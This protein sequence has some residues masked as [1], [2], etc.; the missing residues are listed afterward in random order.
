MSDLREQLRTSLGSQYT[1]ERELGG[2]GMSRVFVAT[3]TRFGR[4][5]VIK[6]LTR[7]SATDFSPARFE[8]EI[9]LAA[10]LQ[11]PH[12]VPVLNAGTAGEGIDAVPFYTMP[13]VEGESLRMRMRSYRVALSDA[14]MMLRDIATALAYA[15]DHGVVHRDIKPENILLSGRTAVVADFGIAKAISA[16]KTHSQSIDAAT[17]DGT[18]TQA[19]M[20]IGTPAYMSPEQAIGGV[21]DARTDI[22]AWGVIA[23]ELLTGAHPFIGKSSPQHLIAAHLTEQPRPIREV[24]ETIPPTL[25]SLVMRALEKDAA[26][27]PQLATELVRV[28]DDRSLLSGAQTV[29]AITAGAAPSRPAWRTRAA[30]VAAVVAVLIVGA[31]TAERGRIAAVLHA[32]ASKTADAD[33]AFAADSTSGAPHAIRLAV[34]PFDNLGDTADAYFADG[35]ADQVRGK[36]TEVSG[37][38]VIARTSSIAYRGTHESPQQIAH[39]LNV[40][41]LLTGTVR[42]AK[43]ANGASRVQVNPELV[44]VTDST[45][46]ASKWQQP[47]DAKLTDVFQVQTD[48]AT[49]VAS[50]LDIAL[51]ADV[52][53]QLAVRPTNSIAAYD[54]YLHGEN[55]ARGAAY[56][57]T[58][59]RAIAYYQQATNLDPNFTLAW[60][61]LSEAA[62]S[63]YYDGEPTAEMDA[64]ARDAADHAQSLAPNS[65]DTYR[66]LA[67]YAERVRDDYAKGLAYSE[68]G[69]R[70]SPSNATLISASAEAD[71]HLGHWTEALAQY[72]RSTSLDPRSVE[73]A[74]GL[75]RSSLYLRHYD[76][77]QVA[78]D[79][80]LALAPSDAIMLLRV[81]VDLA[82]GDSAAARAVI[83]RTLHQANPDA[84]IAT[85]AI[86]WD[87][88]W[89][90]PDVQQQRLEHLTPAAFGGDRGAWGLCL[91]ETYWLRGDTVH[92]RAYADSA[93]IAVEPQLRSMPNVPQHHEIL[94]LAL[95]YLGD[96]SAAIREG[97]RAVALVPIAKDAI[98]GPYYQHQLVR[99]YLIT[100]HPDKALDML[101][102]LLKVPYYLS[103]GWLRIDP[104]FAPL[105]GNPRFERLV[106]GN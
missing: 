48:I 96:D 2:G 49:K 78:L 80:G 65:P 46:P 8:R 97:E 9:Q 58:L 29:A 6:V 13:F 61:G 42:W 101:E 89:V 83:A 67:T 4:T 103:P 14:V 92:A 100:G 84:L 104:T 12:I 56:P 19:G 47:F 95:A 21:V 30:V 3:E 23:Y 1:I 55:L 82:R 51:G 87:L 76:D 32:P 54:A 98:D 71:E 66:A 79:H 72:R 20:S 44:E 90:L 57:P 26:R 37:L 64:T 77:A 33:A 88:Y 36:L 45:A 43:G 59:R 85:V 68:E 53:R 99:I 60:A 27:R 93:R 91:A 22:Y 5:V 70:V 74:L 63:L 17:S 7:E 94:S 81:M 73:T 16:A 75:G 40:R 50:A 105:R 38:A 52:Q 15:H 34:L 106:N 11:E 69:L 10:G 35:V 39:E 31:L 41:Y 102:P 62:S 86:F 25:A 28:L 18:L 24:D